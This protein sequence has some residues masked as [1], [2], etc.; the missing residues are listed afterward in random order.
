MAPKKA[1]RLESHSTCKGETL[2]K[3]ILERD[4]VYNDHSHTHRAL[5]HLSYVNEHDSNLIDDIAK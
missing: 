1:F 5:V 2:S 3:W 4:E